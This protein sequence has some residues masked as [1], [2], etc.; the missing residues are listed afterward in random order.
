MKK[1]INTL[2]VSA[3]TLGAVSVAQALSPQAQE[4]LDKTQISAMQALSAAQ[5]KIGSDAKVKEIEFHH[6]KY[7]KDYFQVEM[8]ANGQKHKVDVDA[9]NGE[10]LGTKSKTPKKVKVQAETAEPKVTFAQ[11]MEIAV[12][13][14]GGKVAEADFHPHKEKAFY[15]IETLVNRQ[16]FVVAVDAEKGQ[17]IDMPKKEKGKHHKHHGKGAHHNSNNEGYDERSK[18]HHEQGGFRQ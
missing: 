15:S 8:F 7:G 12:A 6:T 1:W 2:L 9:N 10:I 4:A 3:M 18:H 17:I 13:K 16:E 14:T 5:N 11:A